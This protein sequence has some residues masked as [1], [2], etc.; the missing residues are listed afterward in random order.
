V[1]AISLFHQQ[2]YQEA[3]DTLQ[4]VV[5]QQSDVAEGYATL[6]SCLGHLGR[7]DGVKANIDKFN[8]ISIPA[9]YDPLTVQ[10]MGWWWYGDMF[11]YDNTY[12]T[13]LLEGLHKANV[14]EGPGT[15]LRYID[16][17]RSIAKD[18]GLYQVLGATEIDAPTAK[19]LWDR[20]GVTF[21]DVRGPGDFRAG[22]IPGAKNISLARAACPK[23]T[24][25]KLL[26]R[27]IV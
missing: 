26:A 1:L 20:G 7:T 27:M 6:V 13:S 4:R 18:H 22:H 21:V 10:E 3:I 2:R 17:R 15:D 11:D 5:S 16:Y 8:A 24:S 9:G 12:R 14:P 23:R 19:A 25:Q